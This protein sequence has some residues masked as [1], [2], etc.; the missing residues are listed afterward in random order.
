MGRRES[1]ARVVDQKLADEI[2]EKLAFGLSLSRAE[3]AELE[4]PLLKALLVSLDGLLFRC[5]LNVRLCPLIREVLP[6]LI[7]LLECGG[8]APVCRDSIRSMRLYWF[9]S[10]S[11]M[12]GRSTV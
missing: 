8:F 11:L 1:L 7:Q 5:G 9:S 12:G 3:F 2:D 4:Q 10:Y 6:E